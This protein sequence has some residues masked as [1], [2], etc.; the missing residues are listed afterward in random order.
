MREAHLPQVI[1][2]ENASFSSPWPLEAFLSDLTPVRSPHAVSL[3]LLDAGRPEAG[4]RGYVC[5]WAHHGELSIHNIAVHA[6]DRRRGGA[7]HLLDAAF[8]EARARGCAWAYLEVRPSNRAAIEMYSRRGFTAAARRRGYYGDTGEDAIVMRA[9]IV[10]A[11]G[12]DTQPAAPPFLKGR[13]R[14]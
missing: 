8:A 1:D 14:R 3:V 5:F 10:A 13:R 12:T 7:S 2:I 11:P 9:A 6:E 4:V